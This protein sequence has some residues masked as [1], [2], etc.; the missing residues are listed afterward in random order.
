MQGHPQRTGHSG[1][2][3]KTSSTAGGNGKPPQCSSCGNLR[4]GQ[5]GLTPK[6]EFP[7]LEGVQCATGQEWRITT[8]GPRE[9]AVAGPKQK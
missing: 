3:D 4:N 1:S 5:K 7:R 8:N 2:S 6:D 9:S